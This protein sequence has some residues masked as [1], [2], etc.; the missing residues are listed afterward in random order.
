MDAISESRRNSRQRRRYALY[1]IALY[2]LIAHF[3]RLGHAQYSR[4]PVTRPGTIK[5]S[6][7][8]NT[9]YK[10]TSAIIREFVPG[11]IAAGVPSACVLHPRSSRI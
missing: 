1:N 8:A 10:A 6:S 9:W 7:S 4:L 2:R 11:V 5:L 3:R